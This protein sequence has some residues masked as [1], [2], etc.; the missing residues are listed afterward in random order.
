MKLSLVDLSIVLVL[1]ASNVCRAQERQA[2]A[3]KPLAPTRRVK[4]L[5][6]SPAPETDP[7][8]KYRLLPSTA[9]LTPG[10][11]A[12]IYLRL[13]SY[14]DVHSVNESLD[15]P[16][17]TEWLALP[18]DKTPLPEVRKYLSSHRYLLDQIDFVHEEE[19]AIGTTRSLNSL[20]TL[21][22]LVCPMLKT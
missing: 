20:K 15:E 5:T 18:I 8:L 4:E 22:R 11:A 6:I 17:L 12:P 14:N 7:P 19:H 16:K 9:T 10:D 13:F 21:A 1:A 3:S 2:A